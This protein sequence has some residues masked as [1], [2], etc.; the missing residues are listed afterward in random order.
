[1]RPAGG[2]RGFARL[3]QTFLSTRLALTDLDDDAADAA[4]AAAACMVAAID[5]ADEAVDAGDAGPAAFL[6]PAL[7]AAGGAGPLLVAVGVGWSTGRGMI[8]PG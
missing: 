4:A 7:V 5:D 6:S 3:G 8:G 1:M 2:A